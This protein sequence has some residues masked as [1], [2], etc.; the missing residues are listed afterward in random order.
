MIWSGRKKG[1]NYRQDESGAMELDQP[2]PSCWLVHF[3]AI[4]NCSLTIDYMDLIAMISFS[5]TNCEIE[6]SPDLPA[7]LLEIYLH[8]LNFLGAFSI[9]YLNGIRSHKRVP[10]DRKTSKCEAI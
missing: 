4:K 3:Q 10:I 7:G 6:L 2:A 9:D 5:H 1:K 8:I